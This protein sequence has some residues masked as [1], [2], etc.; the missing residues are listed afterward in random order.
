MR[1]I[2]S[3]AQASEGALHTLTHSKRTTSADL[4]SAKGKSF[5]A[6]RK[7]EREKEKEKEKEKDG[8]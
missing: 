5:L 8:K 3:S 4:L 2:Y 7:R 1:T 6:L